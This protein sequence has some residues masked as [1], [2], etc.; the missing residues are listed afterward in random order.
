MNDQLFDTSDQQFSFDS[1][2]VTISFKRLNLPGY[3]AYHVS[4]SSD[5]KDIT[6]ARATGMDR[7]YF[8]TSIPEGRQQEAEGVGKL[9]EEY[10]SKK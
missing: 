2:D 5:R 3:V 6:V 4:F 8:W 7:P 10:L 9:I 1:H